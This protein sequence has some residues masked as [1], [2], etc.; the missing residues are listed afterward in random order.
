MHVPVKKA[1]VQ[2]ESNNSNYKSLGFKNLKRVS[3]DN[4]TN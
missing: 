1:T 4:K 2:R 3:H